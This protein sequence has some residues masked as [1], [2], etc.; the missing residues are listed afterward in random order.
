MRVIFFTAHASAGYGM[1]LHI[2]WYRI[3]SIGG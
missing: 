2:V 1:Y 3:V